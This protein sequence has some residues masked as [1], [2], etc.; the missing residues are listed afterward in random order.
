MTK[1]TFLCISESSE[2]WNLIELSNDGFSAHPAL[3][4]YSPLND[5]S[6]GSQ[7]DFIRILMI[8]GRFNNRLDPDYSTWT[9]LI[10]PDD[11]SRKLN[12]APLVKAGFLEIKDFQVD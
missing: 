5:L 11:P 8:A 10:Y 9:H 6:F 7:L 12:I 3:V 1:K 4:E 2:L